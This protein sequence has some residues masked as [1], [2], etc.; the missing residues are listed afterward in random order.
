MFEYNTSIEMLSSNFFPFQHTYECFTLGLSKY[1][2]WLL[3]YLYVNNLQE[4]N[5][6]LKN[7]YSWFASRIIRVF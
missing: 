6:L 5:A 7:M 3:I 1:W 4:I 2:K